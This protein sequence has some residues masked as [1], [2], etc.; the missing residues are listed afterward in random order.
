MDQITIIAFLG[1]A[2]KLHHLGI[3]LKIQ[4]KLEAKI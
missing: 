2:Q 3:D 4:D 1:R